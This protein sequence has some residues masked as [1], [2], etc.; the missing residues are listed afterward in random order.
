MFDVDLSCLW[1][2]SKGKMQH[3]SVDCVVHIYND[4]ATLRY[5]LYEHSSNAR[6]STA[7]AWLLWFVCLSIRVFSACNIYYYFESVCV[8][9]YEPV[10]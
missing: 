1:D 7:H 9:M 4:I 10:D 3:I 6:V 2:S 5:R 8:Y